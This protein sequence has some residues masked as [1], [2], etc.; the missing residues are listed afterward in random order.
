MEFDAIVIGGGHNGLT[1]AALLGKAGRKVLVLERRDRV[2][3]LAA[4]EEFHPGYRVP[5]LLHDTTGLRPFV[6]EALGLERHGFSFRREELPVYAP[7]K[8][9]GGL[10]LHR[11]AEVSAPEIRNFS[12]R[13]ADRY[14]DFRRFLSRVREFVAGMLNKPAPELSQPGLRDLWTLSRSAWELRRLGEKDLLELLRLGPLCAADWLNEWFEGKLLKAALAG[15]AIQGTWMGPWS[16][17]TAANLLF[18][19]SVAGFEVQGGPAALTQALESA[20]RSFGV[21]IRTSSPVAAIRTAGGRAEGV[22]LTSGEPLDCARVIST[23]DPRRTFLGLIPAREVPPGLDSSIRQWRCRGTLAKVHLALNGPLEFSGRPGARLEA[24]RTGEELDELERAF[25]PVKYGECSSAPI[26]D[27]RV[28]TISD[29]SLAPA[30]H[31]VV[32]ILASFAPYDLRAGWSEEKRKSL[33]ES[34]LDV[35]ERFAPAVRSRVVAGEILTPVDLEER[36]SLTGGQI[37]HGEIALDQLFS[38]R[39]APSCARHA[40]PIAGL[41][42]AGGGTHPG[43]GITAAPGAL[44]AAA[45]LSS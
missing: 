10:L 35:L 15:P 7:Q 39:P 27:L 33:G 18:Q 3:G 26:L 25:D 16:A 8:E 21:E 45:V 6:V 2:G 24:V 34:V 11:S 5:G 37:H 4:L 42:L 41:Y 20:A 23:C 30:G 9:G 44:A 22:T 40:T 32:S 1:A 13:D 31:H 17:G 38:L 14:G 36:Y 43:G 19:E 12:A 28:P 29:P